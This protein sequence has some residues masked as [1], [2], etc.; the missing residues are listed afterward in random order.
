MHYLLLCFQ[1]VSSLIKSYLQGLD[2]IKKTMDHKFN[3][4]QSYIMRLIN[5]TKNKI[6]VSE[7]AKDLIEKML[8]FD[9]NKRIHFQ[10]ITKYQIFEKQFQ[11]QYKK[12][13]KQPNNVQFHLLNHNKLNNNLLTVFLIQLE[14]KIVET[15]SQRNNNKDINQNVNAKR[16]ML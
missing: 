16:K 13:S 6:D 2:L 14:N 3:N 7:Q 11:S 5:F 15:K 12:K 4:I 8:Q 1:F 10:I 9:P